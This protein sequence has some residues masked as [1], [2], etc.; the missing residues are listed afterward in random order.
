M[1]LILFKLKKKKIA[2]C[3]I[4]NSYMTFVFTY[5]HEKWCF[6]SFL[7]SKSVHQPKFVS[8]SRIPRPTFLKLMVS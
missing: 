3:L 5:D 1:F 4:S 6:F 7:S 2:Q 8:I